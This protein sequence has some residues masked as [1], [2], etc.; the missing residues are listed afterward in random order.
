MAGTATI[1]GLPPID[2]E[3]LTI[4]IIG[5]VMYGVTKERQL[6]V[7][8]LYEKFNTYISEPVKEWFRKK[9]FKRRYYGRFSD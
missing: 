9:F 2:I 3:A 6:E 1:K 8:P 5:V 7:D 4:I